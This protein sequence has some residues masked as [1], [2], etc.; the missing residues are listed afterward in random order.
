MV[1]ISVI[2][3][4]EKM[5]RIKLG[6]IQKK[7]QR[8]PPRQTKAEEWF[9]Q[10]G[11]SHSRRKNTH[12]GK[13]IRRTRWPQSLGGGYPARQVQAMGPGAGQIASTIGKMQWQLSI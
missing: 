2:T 12:T 5:K 4:D 13:V 1:M 6:I 9:W 10:M 11:R 7:P 8:W 3:N